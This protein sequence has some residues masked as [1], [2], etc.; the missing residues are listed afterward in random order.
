MLSLQLTSESQ[1]RMQRFFDQF[2]TLVEDIKDDVFETV[3]NVYAQVVMDLFDAE[4]EPVA[5]KPLA[6]STM[7]ERAKLRYGTGPI[8]V[9]S[10]KLEESLTNAHMGTQSVEVRTLSGSRYI[11][12]GNELQ[13]FQ[14]GQAS[15]KWWLENRDERFEELDI[16]RPMLPSQQIFDETMKD[17]E[18]DLYAVVE[19]KVKAP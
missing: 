2:N 7:I 8:L 17:H 10:G 4:G 15:F 9:R 3:F 5:W 1:S 13:E 14:T 12:G 16:V 18:A 19:R 6:M 11:E